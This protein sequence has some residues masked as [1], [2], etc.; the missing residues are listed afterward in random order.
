M[1][2][3]S[4][5]GLL[6]GLVIWGTILLLAFTTFWDLFEDGKT[7]KILLHVFNGLLIILFL[8]I[9]FNTNYK[10]EKYKLYYKSGPIKGS[11]PINSIRKLSKN[12]S[13][14]SGLK[15]GLATKGIIIQYNKW[16]ELYISHQDKE[17]LI[18]ALL[19]INNNIEVV[20]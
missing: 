9:W 13:L 15:V 4:A 1:K 5:K 16:D 20:E 14:W 10:I 7:D 18:A 19:T 3:T 8:W 17:A 11:L 2:F 12:K 6:A